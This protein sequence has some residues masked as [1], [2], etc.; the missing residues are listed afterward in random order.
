[1]GPPVHQCS[2]P[3]RASVVEH[4]TKRLSPLVYVVIHR[5]VPHEPLMS[6]HL[7]QPPPQPASEAQRW[8][9]PWS[10]PAWG[11]RQDCGRQPDPPLAPHPRHAHHHQ[12]S[13]RLATAGTETRRGRLPIGRRHPTTTA[14]R[15]APPRPGARLEAPGGRHQRR[16]LMTSPVSP[17]GV[18]DH[19]PGKVTPPLFGA[20]Q[21]LG[22]PGPGLWFHQGLGPG[23]PPLWEAY[24]RVGPPA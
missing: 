18:T 22:G 7:Q 14:I 17:P 21:G 24:A 16:P 3:G 1:M 8:R 12:T 10:R 13:G 11:P 5:D 9:T 23:G 4:D 15:G 20:L 2:K 6:G 19:R